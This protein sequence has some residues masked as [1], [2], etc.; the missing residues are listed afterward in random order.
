MAIPPTAPRGTG[1][2]RVAVDVAQ[3]VSRGVRLEL[4]V[5]VDGH[6]SKLVKAAGTDR[7]MVL[8]HL[9]SQGYKLETTAGDAVGPHS[10][11]TLLR[12][13]KVAVG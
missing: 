9:I 6:P 8:S 5:S 12:Q 3:L 7:L 11:D 10:I 2:Y 1:S 4:T 13:R